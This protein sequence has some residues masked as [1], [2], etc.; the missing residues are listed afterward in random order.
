MT[1]KPAPLVGSISQT[2]PDLSEAAINRMK[3]S[4][5]QSAVTV[6]DRICKSAYAHFGMLR[7]GIARQIKV[8]KSKKDVTT[9]LRDAGLSNGTISHTSYAAD[10]Y[11]LVGTGHL[12]FSEYEQLGIEVMQEMRLVCSPESK[13]K[14]NPGEMIKF[15][16]EGLG[17]DKKSRQIADE[18]RSLRTT[19]L[20]LAEADKAADK[21]AA[22]EVKRLADEKKAE[23]AGEVAKGLAAATK[24]QQAA[25]AV[26]PVTPTT[27]VTVTTNSGTP[28]PSAAATPGSGTPAA[29]KVL[30]MPV[31]YTATD[32]DRDIQAA[33]EKISKSPI[34]QQKAA[35]PIL[36]V[37]LS[38][39]KSSIAASEKP[40]APVKPTGKPAPAA[41]PAKKAA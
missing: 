3:L 35:V 41:K 17:S 28:A 6:V 26:A 37:Y 12:K 32:F 9:I 25:Q 39:L 5:L 1:A 18:L 7:V 8:E 23:I 20:T 11:G 34:A 27:P 14:L 4:E 19:G 31:T 36:E 15:I 2:M 22:A 38:L 29:G 30:T 10:A 24:Q 40:A 33:M 13:K 16:R 21:A